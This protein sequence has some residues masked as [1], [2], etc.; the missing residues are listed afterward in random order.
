MS[1]H[2]SAPHPPTRPRDW[3]P[4]LP[5]GPARACTCRRSGRAIGRASHDCAVP[6]ATPARSTRTRRS[7]S[8]SPGCHL[9]PL[10]V[11]TTGR[12]PTPCRCLRPTD[13]AAPRTAKSARSKRRDGNSRRPA[14]GGGRPGGRRTAYLE[15]VRAERQADGAVRVCGVVTGSASAP[16]D[17][18]SWS[19]DMM[20]LI[21]RSCRNRTAR[22]L[23]SRSLWTYPTRR[24]YVS[25]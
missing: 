17:L 15:A 3:Q 2:V 7:G 1:Q 19:R 9:S 21:E 24:L 4:I 12:S 23:P 14:L 20:P 10:C 11:S 5:A 13:H 25:N 8:L 16:L 18:M 22:R 6:S